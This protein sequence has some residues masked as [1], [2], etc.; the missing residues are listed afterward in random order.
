LTARELEVAR[1]I[2]LGRTN[3]EIADEL[4]ITVGTTG[5]HV[6][7]ILHKLDMRSRHQVATWARGC[8]LVSD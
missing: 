5:I 6:E 2:G 4:V 3:R 1:L 7:H 8:G